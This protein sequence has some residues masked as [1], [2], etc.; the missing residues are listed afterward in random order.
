MGKIVYISL[1]PRYGTPYEKI[2]KEQATLKISY[3]T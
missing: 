3:L 2:L 1:L